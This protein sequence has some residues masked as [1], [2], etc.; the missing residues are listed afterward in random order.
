MRTSPVTGTLPRQT[1]P[2]TQ[3]LRHL[4]A[5]WQPVA[6]WTL[7]AAA[8]WRT[9][10][11]VARY[12]FNIPFSDEWDFAY[13][14]FAPLREQL[15]WLVER[16]GEHRFVLGRVVYLCLLHLTGHDYR[17]GM[18]LSV[19]LLSGTA[20]AL[21]LVARRLRG[22]T[23]LA[24]AAFPL[25]FLHPAHNE[26]L[27]MGYQIVF[28]ITVLALAVFALVV[29]G[30]ADAPP[31]RSA[32]RGAACLAV[33]APGGWLGLLFVPAIGAWVGWQAWRTSG[34]PVR[35]W[36]AVAVVG[37]AA[38]YLGWSGT[39][40]LEILK[41]QKAPTEVPSPAARVRSVA[42]V[43]GIALG[44]GL[45][46]RSQD[47]FFTAGVF[48]LVAQAATG[49][50]LVRV[51]VRRP[52]ERGAA[53]GFVV[54]LVGAVLFELSI[55]YSRGSGL[56]AR[57]TAFTALG[58]AVSL[59]ALARYARWS[60][61]PAAALVAAFVVFVSPDNT[62]YGVG[63]GKIHF[64]Q[65][66]RA[67]TDAR[68]G[69]PVDVLA[70]RHQNFFYGDKT[71]RGWLELWR[72]DFWIV[73]GLPAPADRPGTPMAFGR[74]GV[75]VENRAAYDRYRVDLGGER[76]VSFVRVKFVPKGFAAWEPFV[77]AWTDPR[78]GER[79][80]DVVNPWVWTL[81][82]ET[83]SATFWVDGPITWGELIMGREGCRFD[84]KAVEYGKI[85]RE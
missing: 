31:G 66:Q 71:R 45:G 78:T 82:P 25:L 68:T 65:H 35:R 34:D 56:A 46:L 12:G 15:G 24:D 70:D 21:V 33:V 6:V 27:L 52:G 77:F 37:A 1:V 42:E 7:W 20:A 2:V 51:A 14:T 19:G 39:N 53:L 32:A 4:A 44:S 49:A 75:V 23:V 3:T 61:W 64:A 26:N 80:R 84:V 5:S 22:R 57:Y 50:Y 85:P 67:V 58:V 63:C 79:K 29:A 10:A 43:A 62:A 72:H 11:F 55:G 69:M 54:L 76:E 81:S 47:R 40:L 18:W 60:P 36:G 83:Q 48:L 28:T 59:F 41:H 8:V 30:S 74:D 9:G 17:A 38:V 16:H 73:R 13:V